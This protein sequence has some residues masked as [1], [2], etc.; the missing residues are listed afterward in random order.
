MHCRIT[1]DAQVV[2]FVRRVYEAFSLI[3]INN[4]QL[5]TVC[6]SHC[7][8]PSGILFTTEKVK[9]RLIFFEPQNKYYYLL[10]QL[11]SIKYS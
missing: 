9:A 11:R 5:Q 4:Q 3:S 8:M 7:V 2:C 6:P 1:D 10:A